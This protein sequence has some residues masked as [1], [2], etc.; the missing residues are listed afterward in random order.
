[1]DTERGRVMELAT[2]KI[3]VDDYDIESMIEDTEGAKYCLLDSGEICLVCG[4]Y[5]HDCEGEN[6]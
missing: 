5:K 6:E 3:C 4:I 1:M 2:C